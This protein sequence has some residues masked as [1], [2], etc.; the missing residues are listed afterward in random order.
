MSYDLHI[1]EDIG[2]TWPAVHANVGCSTPA[3]DALIATALPATLESLHGD[4]APAV[5][6]TLAA[7]L[8][9]LDTGDPAYLAASNLLAACI[10]AC[11][12][13]PPAAALYVNPI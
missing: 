10:A 12:T 4:A 2:H 7:T 9:G 8:A 5:A 6:A 11:D 3:V 1:I 13:S